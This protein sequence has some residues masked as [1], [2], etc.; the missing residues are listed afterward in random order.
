MGSQ[1]VGAALAPL[2][3]AVTSLV[4]ERALAAHSRFVQ[5]IRRRYE[6]ELTLLPAG[7]PDRAA[8][9]RYAPCIDEP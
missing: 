2:S 5:R 3:H 9:I 1:H 6:A 4:R 8:M 7:L